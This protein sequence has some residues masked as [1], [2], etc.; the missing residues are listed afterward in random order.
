MWTD[1]LDNT[2][3]INLRKREDRLLKST[4]ILEDYDIPYSLVRA[5]DD[6]QG[7]RGLRDTML[8]IFQEAIEKGYKNIWVM[9]DDIKMVTDKFWFHETMKEAVKQ[10]PENYHLLYLGGQPTNGY[11]CFYAPNLLPAQKYFATHSVI[12]SQQ[13]IKEILGRSMSYPI[14]N[15]L[16]DEIQ[17]LGHCY[18]VHPLLCSQRADVSDIGGQFI[19]WSPF[20]EAKH[21][22]K[23]NEIKR[24]W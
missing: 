6:E 13:G 12:Y 17:I 5:I 22:Q 20:I 21:E 9:E 8:S 15:W 19:D 10:L 7:A 16:V 23:V 18:A 2:Y 1:F 3:L 11:P 4:E 14:D 24:H